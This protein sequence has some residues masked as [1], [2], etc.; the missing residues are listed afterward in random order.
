M[1][2]SS[3]LLAAFCTVDRSVI[4][5]LLPW[6]PDTIHCW[7]YSSS[8]FL[9][10]TILHPSPPHLNAHCA[11]RSDLLKIKVSPCP[12]SITRSFSRPPLTLC[13]WKVRTTLILPDASRSPG[14]PLTICWHHSAQEGEEHLVTAPCVTSTDTKMN[15]DASV[16]LEHAGSSSRSQASGTTQAWREK[17]ALLLFIGRKSRTSTWAPLPL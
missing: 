12:T 6:L 15:G 3:G 9:T 10:F 13:Q 8:L 5:F 7:F 11:L 16:L 4:L 2:L 14:S 17:P 1:D